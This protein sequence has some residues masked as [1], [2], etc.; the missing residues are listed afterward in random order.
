MKHRMH[1]IDQVYDKVVAEI[2]LHPTL[3]LSAV[4]FLP[5]EYF[6]TDGFKP[7]K[8]DQ[9][10]VMQFKYYLDK[11]LKKAVLRRHDNGLTSLKFY[12][13]LF[14]R[15][16]F[17]VEM[18]HLF[19]AAL[20]PFIQ[21]SE[22][23]RQRLLQKYKIP[24]KS[25]WEHKFL[26]D[27]RTNTIIFDNKG[28]HIS[29]FKIDNIELPLFFVVRYSNTNEIK[30]ILCLYQANFIT[31][32][33]GKIRFTFITEDPTVYEIYFQRNQEFTATHIYED[34][35]NTFKVEQKLNVEPWFYFKDLINVTANRCLQ[36]KTREA[37]KKNNEIIT[38][39][40]KY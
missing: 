30:Q 25:K 22:S 23:Q 38:K 12:Y 8:K 32:T 19:T 3:L 16:E 14:L 2:F 36:V 7:R 33:G 35:N 11:A 15:K 21:L 31:A 18:K 26:Y 29:T 1:Q 20:T 6:R 40:Y 17:P 34:E 28:F 13:F 4:Y 24:G 5:A 37:K 9:F 27:F 39:L 10:F